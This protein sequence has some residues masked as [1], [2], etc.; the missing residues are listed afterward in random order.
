MA[1]GLCRKDTCL[2]DQ[3]VKTTLMKKYRGLK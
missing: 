3:V 1:Q 2:C